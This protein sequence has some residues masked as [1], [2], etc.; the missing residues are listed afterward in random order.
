MPKESKSEKRP[1]DMIGAVIRVLVPR[2]I[3][4]YVRKEMRLARIRRAPPKLSREE[5]QNYWIAPPDEKNLPERY[6]HGDVERSG[7][8][9]SLV[10]RLVPRDAAI[11]E[12]GCNAGRNLNHLYHH[13]FTNLS[14]IEISPA[15]IAFFGE[16]FPDTA[17]AVDVRVGPLENLLPGY[18]ERRF[19]LLFSMAVMMHIHPDSAFVFPHMVRISGMIL[20]VEDER[21]S[22]STRHFGRNYREIFEALGAKQILE[23]SPV[24]GL[25]E[26]VARVFKCPD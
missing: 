5:A 11:L 2:P 22:T 16:A 24:A 13:G 15:A 10:E 20:A 9:L 12:I 21:K 7:A 18:P 25:P 17:K 4:R 1:A 8:L 14:A 6:A 3:R 19:D 26:F 23:E